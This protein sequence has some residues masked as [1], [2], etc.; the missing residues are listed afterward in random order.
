MA[1]FMFW[2]TN[3]APLYEEVGNICREYGVDIAIFAESELQVPSLLEILNQEVSQYFSPVLST[4][5]WIQFYTRYPVEW[6]EPRLDD[7]GRISM[8]LLKHPLGREL[9]IVAVHRLANC[10][11]RTKTSHSMR[12]ICQR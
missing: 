12:G 7:G 2:N 6:L 8:P 9:L 4:E 3:R 11:R 5:G 1:V 10:I